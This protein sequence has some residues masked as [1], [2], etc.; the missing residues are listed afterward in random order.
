MLLSSICFSHDGKVYRNPNLS[1]SRCGE[2]WSTCCNFRFRSIFHNMSRSGIVL[3]CSPTVRSSSIS[4]TPHLWKS[5]RNHFSR[6]RTRSLDRY[7]FSCSSPV[8]K[9][10]AP[11]T[12]S[13]SCH[14]SSSRIFSFRKFLSFCLLQYGYRYCKFQSEKNNGHPRKIVLEVYITY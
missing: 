14:I 1:Y 3:L 10:Q 13:L 2:G 8:V 4:N 11:D 9:I 12:G 7:N 5:C 6:N